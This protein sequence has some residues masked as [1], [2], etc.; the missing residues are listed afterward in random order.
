MNLA[1]VVGRVWATRKAPGLEQ[2]ALLVIQPVDGDGRPE[3]AL[4]AAVDLMG[5]ARG[6]WVYFVASKEAALPL[7]HALTPVDA[8][9]V[10]IVDHV[11]R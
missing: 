11:D 1:R 10:G 9:I 4:L 3:G 6:Q 8:T 7:P 5:S 2:A